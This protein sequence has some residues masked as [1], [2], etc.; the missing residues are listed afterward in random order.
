LTLTAP[1][2]GNNPDDFTALNSFRKTEPYHGT[3]PYWRGIL[4]RESKWWAANLRATYV[5]GYR[6]FVMDELSNG[7]NRIGVPTQ[8]QIL[9]FGDA[10]RPTATGNFTFSLFPASFVTITNQTS[11]YHIRMQGNSFY[12][13]ADNG[14][15]PR[16]VLNFEF[17]GIRTLANTTD[18]ELR[19]K[20]WFSV[21]AGYAYD[22]RRIRSIQGFEL[23]PVP[24]PDSARVP[25]EQTNQLHS[26]I[27]GVRFKPINFVTINL[28]A[29]IGRADRPIYPI[30]ERNY[31]ALRG[32][33]EYKKRNLRLAAYARTN[34]NTN[35]ASL[36]NYASK[37]RQ[38]GLDASWSFK[39]WFSI[40]AGYGKQH[41]DTLGALD[42]F[43]AVSG[44]NQLVT[45]DRSYYVSNIHTATLLARFEIRRRADFSVGYS[46]I[47]DLGDGRATAVGA[48]LYSVLPAFQAAQTFPLRFNSPQARLSVVLT[49]KIR[50]NAGYQF[51]GYREEFATN[52]NYRAHTGYSS[53]SWTF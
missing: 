27:L 9:A 33:I 19:V 42:Y 8:R 45:S 21:H 12:E 53:V 36:A 32:R 24:A 3:S 5:A 35:S 16:P 49:P 28:D 18:A 11:L 38:Y 29:E 48:G 4:F 40:D 7:E 1:S 20:K 31:Q 13:Q 25:Y 34:Y 17:L 23:P 37:S 51:Y 47:Q 41:L 6:G 15:V 46:H 26:G 22:N 2:Q 14:A 10:R 39:A 50:W 44:P 30:S 52:Q 43:A